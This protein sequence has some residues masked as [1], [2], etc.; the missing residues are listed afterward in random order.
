MKAVVVA[1]YGPPEGLQLVELDK[2]V[3]QENEVLIRVH[4]TTVTAGDV[5]LRSMTGFERLLMGLF[6][7]LGKD[8]ILGHELAGEIESVGGSVTRLKPGASVFAS[9]GTRSGAHAEY[10]LL[11]EDGLLALKPSNLSFGESAALPVGANTALDILRKADIQ[12]GQRVLVYGASGSVGTYAVQLSQ[13]W[14]AEVTGVTSTTNLELVKSIGAKHVIDYTTE[15][16]STL[17]ETYDVI[18]D[19]VRKIDTSRGNK[20]LH[21]GGQLLSTATTTNESVEN[22]EFIRQLAE[23]GDLRPVIDRHYRLDQ[24]QDAHR[25]VDRGHKK[26]NV[27]ITVSEGVK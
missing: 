12:S 10:V 17:G 20:V 24:I 16:F 19:T 11:P 25:Y 13:Y 15:D 27:V 22:L 5:M 7:G 23:A 26:G 3:P 8:K 4:A 21:P 18:F 9:M 14:G 1:R 6:F 2:P